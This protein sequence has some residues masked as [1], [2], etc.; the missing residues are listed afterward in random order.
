VD[1]PFSFSDYRPGNFTQSF[2]GPVSASEALQR[3][4]NIPAVDIL[5]R[6]SPVFFDTRMRQGGLHLRFPPHQGP[7][8]TMILGGAGTSLENLVGAYTAFARGGLAGKL[9]HIVDDPLVERRMMRP[10]AAYV[11]RQILQEHRR[12]DIPG[13]RVSLDRSRHAAWKPEPATDFVMLG[14]SA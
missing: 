11:I 4:L 8:L 6:L 10:G 14:A 12:P 9:R 13:G 5:D 3:S 2:S 1:A 7:N